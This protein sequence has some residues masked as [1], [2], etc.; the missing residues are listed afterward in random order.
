MAKTFDFTECSLK[1]ELRAELKDK[2]SMLVPDFLVDSLY[3]VFFRSFALMTKY[4]SN[5]ST[6]KVGFSFKDD[7]GQ[8]KLGTIQTYNAPE[9]EESEDEGNYNLS[10]T[11][12]EKDMEGCD[13]SLDTFTDAFI[14]IVQTELFSDAHTHC[15]S[16]QDLIMVIAEFIDA[17]KIFLDRNSNDSD[18][19]VVLKMNGVF[20][21][22]VGIENGT[23]VFSITPGYAV[24]QIVKNDDE[25]EKKEPDVK[26]ATS[27]GATASA[28]AFNKRFGMFQIPIM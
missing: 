18:E 16:N 27:D 9:D 22:A 23:K 8:F 13:V 17:I 19:D 5:K 24:K 6:H 26:A 20:E 7:K 25:T 2:Y 10:M 3:R 28:A 21:A 14:T 11:F 1:Q 15:D 12:Y 4:H